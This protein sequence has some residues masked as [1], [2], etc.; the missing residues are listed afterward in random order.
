MELLPTP[1]L[2]VSIEV[3]VM[4]SILCYAAPS[5][6]TPTHVHLNST[7]KYTLHVNE[8]THTAQLHSMSKGVSTGGKKIFFS[9]PY[10]EFHNSM[11][12]Q[13]K[14]GYKYMALIS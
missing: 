10:S 12:D 5:S 11:V 4:I 1:T 13:V 2:Y 9:L 3:T 6:Y 14:I 7:A 8:D